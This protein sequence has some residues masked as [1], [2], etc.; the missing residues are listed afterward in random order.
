[1]ATPTWWEGES[2]IANPTVKERRPNFKF[3]I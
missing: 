1:M 2:L 3:Y